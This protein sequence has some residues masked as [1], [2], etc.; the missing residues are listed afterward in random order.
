MTSTP[1]PWLDDYERLLHVL[2]V[3]R[4]WSVVRYTF[5]IAMGIASLLAPS[6]VLLEQ[7]TSTATQV[8]SVLW[9]AC[10]IACLVSSL[11]DTRSGEYFG[12]PGVIMGLGLWGVALLIQAF[13][14]NI[15]T[16]PYV[17]LIGA[18]AASLMKRETEVKALM[19]VSEQMERGK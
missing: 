3:G 18:L 11:R 8:C 15:I 4:R 7:T 10:S 17:C 9:V 13:T 6:V 1:D 5:L 12:I 19:D 16:L 2:T 14:V